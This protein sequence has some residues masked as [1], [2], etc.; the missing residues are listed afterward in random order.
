[1]KILQKIELL[2]IYLLIQLILKNIIFRI[3]ITEWTLLS[4]Y[5]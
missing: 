3:Y 4:N 2:F 5:L 1:M